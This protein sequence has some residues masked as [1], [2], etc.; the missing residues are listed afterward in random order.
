MLTID[1]E[2]LERTRDIALRASEKIM[3]IYQ[4]D[5]NVETKGDNSPVTQADKLA[6]E[7]I[8]KAIKAEISDLVPIIG[9]E[10]VEEGTAPKIEGNMFW[11]VDPLDGTKEFVN[12]NGEFTVNIALIENG[13][14]ILGVVDAPAIKT[15][16]WAARSIGAFMQ[17]GDKAAQPITCRT[18]PTDG[19]SAM[20][21]RSHPSP[22]VEG[23]LKNYNI[24][25][26]VSSGSSLK[27]CRV[28]EGI[29]DI[30][31]RMGRTMEWDTA[32][33]HAVL[34]CAGGRVCKTDGTDLNYAKPGLENPHFIAIGPGI[35][36]KS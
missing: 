30:Y 33:G 16:Y 34:A 35:E 4:T 25:Q 19:L 27:F 31:P 22:E 24:A 17:S 9:E 10:S 18:P 8:I 11:L 13:I 32:A 28:A 36:I 23:F 6:E 5:F 12:K 15:T 29:A 20:A 14:P 26:R 21:S 7:L 3:E 2:L 1:L